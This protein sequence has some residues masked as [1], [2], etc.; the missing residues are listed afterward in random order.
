[1]LTAT[2]GG[3]VNVVTDGIWADADVILIVDGDVVDADNSSRTNVFAGNTISLEVGG[4]IGD[5]FNPF[6]ISA[7][8][9]L[10]LTYTG[11]GDRDPYWAVL[12]G[13]I[14]G[15][16]NPVNPDL[17]KYLGIPDI[18]PGI[19][20]YNGVVIGGPE[21]LINRFLRSQAFNVL[22]QH[23]FT[24]ERD[25]V[26]ELWPFFFS[27][28]VVQNNQYYPA[29][30]AFEIINQGG[31]RVYGVPEGLD[32]PVDVNFLLH[33]DSPF[34]VNKKDK[35]GTAQKKIKKKGT[36]QDSISDTEYREVTTSYVNE[37][38]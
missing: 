28:A 30:G 11:S 37:E 10:L 32:E 14:L 9:M 29:V 12:T 25:A 26:L 15:D 33:H 8:N 2:D 6:D 3:N 18:P 38:E 5:L 16:A 17:P 36:R 22:D 35:G 4:F 20:I 27:H 19:I 1:M 31:V 21:A 24:G 34:K 7:E 13:Q 23:F